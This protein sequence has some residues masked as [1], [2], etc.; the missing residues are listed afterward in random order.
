MAGIT[1]WLGHDASEKELVTWSLWPGKSGV[2]LKVGRA[3]EPRTGRKAACS[4]R[5]WSVGSLELPVLCL[6]VVKNCGL[7]AT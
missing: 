4:F 7:G 2:T 1:E 5:A 6:K 3:L